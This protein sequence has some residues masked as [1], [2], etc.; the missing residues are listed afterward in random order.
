MHHC[1]RI[2]SVMRVSSPMARLRHKRRLFLWCGATH[3]IE[4]LQMSMILSILWWEWSTTSLLYG[5]AY[6]LEILGESSFNRVLPFPGSSFT[7]Y[8]VIILIFVPF[9]CL[10]IDIMSQL[11]ITSLE[12][13][14]HLKNII[15]DSW[16][17]PSHKIEGKNQTKDL[18]YRSSNQCP[19]KPL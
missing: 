10:F 17:I 11:K 9:A 4:Q 5:M 12:W 16:N 3:V 7:K 14:C 1:C 19:W 18:K 8:V 6:L 15:P 2:L 13:I